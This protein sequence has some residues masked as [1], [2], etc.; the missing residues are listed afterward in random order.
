MLGAS[1]RHVG[2]RIIL[3]LAVLTGFPL[4]VLLPSAFCLLKK[5]LF[6]SPLDIIQHLIRCSEAP[7]V[8]VASQL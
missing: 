3:L 5:A 4:A 2:Q 7:P 6:A 1:Q 8:Q